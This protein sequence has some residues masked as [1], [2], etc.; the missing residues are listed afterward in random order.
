M[1]APVSLDAAAARGPPVSATVCTPGAFEEQPFCTPIRQPSHSKSRPAPSP[2]RPRLGRV[3]RAPKAAGQKDHA[4]RSRVV[5]TIPHGR[6]GTPIFSAALRHNGLTVRCAFGQH[7][8]EK[9]AAVCSWPCRVA[10]RLPAASCVSTS[11]VNHSASGFAT[12]SP[13]S[14]R[15]AVSLPRWPPSPYPLS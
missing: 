9:R 12:A 8:I 14:V 15:R 3:L 4:W 13:A 2:Q 7:P 10:E 1:C 6:P 5:A 11:R